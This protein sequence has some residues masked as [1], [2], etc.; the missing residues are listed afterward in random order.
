MDRP[1]KLYWG[2]NRG[3]NFTTATAQGEQ[4]AL[5]VGYDFIRVEGNVFSSQQPN[6]VPLKLYWHPNRGDNFTT[7]TDQGEKDAH[8]VGYH[9]IRIE[10]FVYPNQQKDTIPLKLYWSPERE[11][12]FLTATEQGEKDAKEAGYIFIRNEG[13]ITSSPGFSAIQGRTEMDFG[14]GKHGASHA[15]LDPSGILTVLTQTWTNSPFQG[16]T[17]GVKVWGLDQNQTLLL[18]TS[19]GPGP[20][21]VDGHMVPFG[22]PSFRP[23]SFTQQFPAATAA[24]VR[25]LRVFVFH[26]PKWRIVEIVRQA[27]E[28]AKNLTEAIDDFCKKNPEICAMV[29]AALI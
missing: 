23:D 28:V 25:E 27:G 6:T 24:E 8:D 10:G 1:L 4:D 2:N 14:G 3:D 21:G 26:A 12:N 17:M 19:G 13:F 18:E 22:A 16:F 9:F 11:D 7:A 15:T 20:Y 5:A 29:K